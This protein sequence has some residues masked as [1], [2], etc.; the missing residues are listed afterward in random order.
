MTTLTIDPYV[1]D[2]LMPDLVGHDKKPSAF[3][4]YLY[5]WRQSTIRKHRRVPASLATIA[6]STG[7]SRRAVQNALAVLARRKLILA[8]RDGPTAIPVYQP[9]SPWRARSA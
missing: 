9:Q 8:E 2:T 1:I 4:V 3:L 5:L 7:L 6:E